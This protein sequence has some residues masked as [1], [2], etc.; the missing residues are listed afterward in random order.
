M[1]LLQVVFA[2]VLPSFQ[3][4]IT[5]IVSRLGFVQQILAAFLGTSVDVAV[6]PAALSAMPWA[7]PL[8]LA[9]LWTHAILQ[10]ARVPAGEIDRGT[11]DWL[12]S[13]PV[14]RTAVYVSHAV[15]WLVSGGIV[16]LGGLLGNVVGGLYVPAEAGLSLGERLIINTNLWAMFACVGGLASFCSAVS[17]R[18]GRAA[19]A[20]FAVVL[21]SF[22]FNVFSVFNETFRQFQFLGILNYHRPL[23]VMTSD[24]WPVRDL[25]VLAIAGLAFWLAGAAIFS[26]RD[27]RTV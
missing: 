20:A 6:G 2:T 16:V 8:V 14:G 26:R 13:L 11:I 27:L 15:V 17:N 5:D 24:R 22:V 3:K 21:G 23:Q 9:L 10:G 7:H 18:R 25:A 12:L 19:G 1:V 4:D